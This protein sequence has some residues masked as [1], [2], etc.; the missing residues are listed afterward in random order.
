MTPNYMDGVRYRIPSKAN[1]AEAQGW[2]AR[3][4]GGSDRECP[5]SHGETER[6][7]WLRGYDMADGRLK[8]IA[9]G[10]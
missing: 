10:R 9:A 5:Y 4:E 1:R 8:R 2:A 3:M 6:T 7:D